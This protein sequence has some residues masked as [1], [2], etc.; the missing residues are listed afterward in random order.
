MNDTIEII[1]A[2]IVDEILQQRLVELGDDTD[3][4]EAGLLTSLD[5]VGLVVF[6]EERFGVEIPPED[7]VEEHFATLSDIAGLITRRRDARDAA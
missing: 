1:R 4:I 3:L 6:L 7:V 2:H 5:V